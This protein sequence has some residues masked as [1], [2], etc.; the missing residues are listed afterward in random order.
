[1][2]FY[3]SVD[4]ALKHTSLLA[5]ILVP[6]YKRS[7]LDILA[8]NSSLVYHHKISINQLY[9][10]LI[11]NPGYLQHA[12]KVGWDKKGENAFI[13]KV[14]TQC[15]FVMYR[16]QLLG[17]I[18]GYTY[19]YSSRDFEID[20][21]APS[22]DTIIRTY[23]VYLE[24]Y[25]STAYVQKRLFLLNDLLNTGDLFLSYTLVFDDLSRFFDENVQKKRNQALQ[26][27]YQTADLGIHKSKEE[28][29]DLLDHYFNS[30]FISDLTT[31]TDGGKEEK[32]E[33][34]IKY[35]NEVADPAKGSRIE[36]LEH[37][38]G[39]CSR[40]LQEYPDNYVL[41]I[42]RSMTLLCLANST[43]EMISTGMNYFSKGWTSLFENIDE[44]GIERIFDQVYIPF[45]A[46]LKQD[47]ADREYQVCHRII[48]SLYTNKLVKNH[49][50]YLMK[51]GGTNGQL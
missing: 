20:F 40:L 9:K 13:E 23:E 7:L 36:N 50:K 21:K 32:W 33:T 11:C 34:I 46:V 4:F 3:F 27:M 44:D 29:R 49:N 14:K 48:F 25:R 6:V 2:D 28:I 1:K 8:L 51:Y 39:A 5:E 45:L 18:D 30:K 26:E 42:L 19:D 38:E 43:Q 24:K 47:L 16:L 15:E 41:L 17:V 31:D 12:K 37:M 10:S 22:I 35:I